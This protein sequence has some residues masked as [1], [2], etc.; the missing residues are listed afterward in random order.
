V[1]VTTLPETSPP[2]ERSGARLRDAA[3][4]YTALLRN[5]P[6]MLYVLTGACLLGVL[7]AYITGSSFLYI[8]NLGVTPSQFALLFAFNAL[9]FIGATQLNR[10][11]L[12]HLSLFTITRAAVI[13]TVVFS[14][15]LLVVVASGL[16][17]TLSLTLLLFTLSA[18][19]GCGF[20]NNA[21]LAFGTVRERM[22][23]AS[24]LQGTTQSVFG[25]IAGGL[26]SALGNGATLPLMGI[27]AGFA[28]LAAVFLL[29]AHRNAARGGG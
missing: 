17:S 25:G 24:A 1:S 2:L 22:G 11:L 12:R 7:F 10:V 15:L 4:T 26:V 20:P 9:G 19:L 29:A 27:M 13:A 23:S 6:F 16:S 3:G 5:A 18:A 8:N 14:L 21:A 28:I